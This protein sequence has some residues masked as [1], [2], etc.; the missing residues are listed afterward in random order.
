M[1]IEIL[2]NLNEITFKILTLICTTHIL[3]AHMWLVAAALDGA[4]T[5]Y[6]ITAESPAGWGSSRTWR[7]SCQAGHPSD[8]APAYEEGT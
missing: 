4:D 3:S 1:A 5:G 6:T 2:I 8:H 7:S